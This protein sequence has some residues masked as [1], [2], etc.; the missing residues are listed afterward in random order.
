MEER[1]RSGRLSKQHSRHIDLHAVLVS[2]THKFPHFIIYVFWLEHFEVMIKLLFSGNLR[3]LL[4]AQII[5]VGTIKVKHHVDKVFSELGHI[6][7]AFSRGG[8]AYHRF[9]RNEL[10][11]P[12][13]IELRHKM[14]E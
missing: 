12:N 6:G 9:G 7:D 13:S 3:Y 10:H 2:H 5:L 4:K 8:N 1:R 11:L 14:I